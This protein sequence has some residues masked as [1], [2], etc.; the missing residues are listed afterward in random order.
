MNWNAGEV[1]HITVDTTYNVRCGC[2]GLGHWEAFA[3]GSG[4]PKFFH[5][6]HTKKNVWT[7]TGKGG[8]LSMTDH[9]TCSGDR[10]PDLLLVCRLTGS[11]QQPRLS[12]VITT[13]YN[14]DLIILDGTLVRNYPSLVAGKMIAGIERYLRVP[15][16]RIT[17]LDWKAQ[18]IWVAEAAF[19]ITGK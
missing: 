14:P 18:V 9:I 2:G 11:G 15:E 17:T 19:R 12:A 1:G 13:S 3:S 7:L 4:I 10:Q 6:W 5:T 16:I 8:H